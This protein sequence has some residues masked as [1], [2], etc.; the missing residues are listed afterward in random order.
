MEASWPGRRAGSF[1]EIV[2]RFILSAENCLGKQAHKAE[3][4]Y[5][6]LTWH[7]TQIP[8]SLVFQPDK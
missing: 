6:I 7:V 4:A 3:C 8:T 1:A 5:V 2:V